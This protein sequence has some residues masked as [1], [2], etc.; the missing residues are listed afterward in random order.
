VGGINEGCTHEQGEKQDAYKRTCI[1]ACSTT[2][3]TRASTLRFALSSAAYP[4]HVA[5]HDRNDSVAI[6]SQPIS[7]RRPAKAACCVVL[8]TEGSV[9][10]RC[11]HT[12][13]VNAKEEAR[14]LRLG[15]RHDEGRRGFGEQA[16]KSLQMRACVREWKAFC[17]GTAEAAWLHT[18]T[19]RAIL[20]DRR[21]KTLGSWE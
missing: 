15:V 8:Q 7:K 13:L 2:G 4:C 17:C 19:T 10:T 21:N 5:C 1:M 20:P 12:C 14:H 3:M 9:P 18:T 11:C 6:F 16:E